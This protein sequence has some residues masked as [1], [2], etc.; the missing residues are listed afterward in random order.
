MM[1]TIHLE[2]NVGEGRRR[3]ETIFLEFSGKNLEVCSVHTKDF[4]YRPTVRLCQDKLSIGK[5]ST[6]FIVF[7]DT[8]APQR[9]VP[10]FFPAK[11][12]NTSNRTK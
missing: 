7:F 8:F 4:S 10:Y 3:E 6:N 9:K 2:E 1:K 12:F 11:C 5:D